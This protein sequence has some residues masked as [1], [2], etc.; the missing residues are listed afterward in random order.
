[1]LIVYDEHAPML[2]GRLCSS[3]SRGSLRMQCAD[4]SM[5]L[6]RQV[7]FEC[8]RWGRV[9]LGVA[10]ADILQQFAF[11]AKTELAERRLDV[12]RD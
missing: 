7:T 2:G 10:S 4:F 11:R 6:Y 5:S 3:I 1:M 9:S 12:D 8:D